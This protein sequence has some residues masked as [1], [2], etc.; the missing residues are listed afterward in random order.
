MNLDPLSFALSEIS[1]TVANLTKK[2][3]KQSI[4]AIN[5]VRQVCDLRFFFFQTLT[6]NMNMSYYY[7]SASSRK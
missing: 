7:Y 2:N 3:Y 5:H 4:A 6:F 1:Y